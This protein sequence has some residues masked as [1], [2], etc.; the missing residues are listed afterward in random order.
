MQFSNCSSTL[1]T[2]AE[3]YFYL[4]WSVIPLHGDLDSARPKVPSIPWA[5]HQQYRPSL[6]DH[7]QWTTFGGLGIVTG[8][9][10]QLVVLDFDSEEIFNDFRLKYPDLIDTH[11]VQSAGRQLPHLYFKL[12]DHLHLDS[13]KGQGI[14]LLSNGRYVVAPPTTINGQTYKITRGGIP[15]TLSERDIRRIQAFLDAHKEDLQPNPTKT[16]QSLIITLE[17]PT[18]K[19]L[20]NLYHQLTQ[21]G[22][23]NEALF[24]TSLYARDT[25]WQTTET[26]QCLI[27]LHIQLSRQHETAVQRQREALATIRSAFS[28]PARQTTVQAPQNTLQLSNS[29]REA[30]LQR[31]L[32]CVV[33]TYEGLLQAGIQ[34]GAVI[35]TKDTVDRLKGQVGRFSILNALKAGNGNQ[36]F[37]PSVNLPKTANAVATDKNQEVSKNAFIEGS[38]LQQKPQGGRPQYLFRI[39]TNDDL[40]AMLG[41]KVT[42]S[43]L[44]EPSDLTSAHQTR[45]ALHRELIKRRPGQYPRRWLAQRLGVNTRTIAA[46]NNLIPIHSKEMHIETPI[47]WKT[48]ECLPFDEPLQGAVLVTLR[49]KRYPALRTIASRLLARGEGIHLKQ[50]TVNFYWY[51]DEEPLLAR[52]QV[53]QEIEVRQEHIEAFM[54]QQETVKSVIQVQQ[55][56][57]VKQGRVETKAP[58][59]QNYR[60]PLKNLTHEAL[61]QQVYETLDK[62]LSLINARRTV[63]TY[64]QPAISSALDLLKK[65]KTIVNPVGFMLTML[66]STHTKRSGSSHDSH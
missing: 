23:R 54:A 28:R 15:R 45:M 25:G 7:Q 30:L 33:R 63:A 4:G 24:R 55:P 12:P 44:L 32:T 60:K 6:H 35:G 11:T 5:V 52:L 10:S 51:G 53:Q 64:G 34:P 58:A 56:V 26:Q 21:R 62:Q 36:R 17:K 65:R 49:G 20:R 8:R 46:Y 38:N 61:A 29:V 22:G 59:P 37:F 50:Q 39:P 41:V 1:L 2:A 40:C 66:Q 42:G 13:Q 43:D 27:P 3:A 19:D 16:N 48:I 9:V 18:S 57:V 14:D 47:T 31:K